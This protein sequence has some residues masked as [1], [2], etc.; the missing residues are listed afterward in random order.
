[1][2]RADGRSYVKY[3]PFL[4]AISFTLVFLAFWIARYFLTPLGHD[5]SCLL[6]EAGRFLAGNEIYGPHLRELNPP[7]IIWF[8]AIPIL[9]SHHLSV[10]VV[11]LFRSLVLLMVCMNVVWCVSL[12]ARSGKIT[13]GVALTLYGI[14]VLQVQLHIWA[15]DF[16]QREHLLVLL[17]FPYLLATATRVAR[18]SPLER[19]ALGLA[20]GS[21]IWLKPHQ[22]L[23]VIGFELFCALRARSLRHIF[24]VEFISMVLTACMLLVLVLVYTPLY[25]HQVVPLLSDVYWAYGTDTFTSLLLRA[26]LLPVVF[27][28]VLLYCFLLL[29]LLKDWT[30]PAALLVCSIAGYF[31]FAVQQTTWFYHLYPFLAFFFFAL[32]YLLVDIFHP[33]LEKIG[34]SP[35]LT[36]R[37]ALALS[38]CAF[39]LVIL[40]MVHPSIVRNRP[41][42][43]VSAPLDLFFNQVEPGTTVYVFS[44]S[45][46][47]LASAYKHDL[48]WGSRYAGLWMLP[49]IIQNEMGRTSSST[50]FKKLSAQTTS[51]LAAQQR[52]EITE[53]LNYWQPTIVLI[54]L[55]TR[56]RNCQG[57]EGKDIDLLAWFKRSPDFARTW[58][59]Y[60]RQSDIEGYEVYRLAR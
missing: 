3:A 57:M 23:V 55:C 19:G 54:S 32:F 28:V 53:D 43:T 60:D 10:P 12:L 6:F 36:G 8:S 42:S 44:T 9:L 39:L 34:E 16:G 17:L 48:N 52:Q 11:Y 41:N 29:S 51:R 5:Q 47:S 2:D 18:L 21:A 26:P 49:A 35:F 1:M 30:I 40:F 7:V 14:F 45:V 56:E 50:P 4:L 59:R 13:S 15:S 24:S 38:G 37:P 27:L 33:F 31:A 22:I 25:V 46:P 20:A 58:L